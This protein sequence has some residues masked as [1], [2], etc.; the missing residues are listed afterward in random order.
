MNNS[1]YDVTIRFIGT[2]SGVYRKRKFMINIKKI[3]NRKLNLIG[4]DMKEI[5][6]G[7]LYSKNN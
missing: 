2:F 1:H 3:K 6:N 4:V 5:K 7:N